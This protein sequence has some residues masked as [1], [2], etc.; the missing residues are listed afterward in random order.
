MNI[1]PRDQA[2][3]A[4]DIT[5]TVN[6][7]RVIHVAIYFRDGKRMNLTIPDPYESAYQAQKLMD[8]SFTFQ[9]KPFKKKDVTAVDVLIKEIGPRETVT[10]ESDWQALERVVKFYIERWPH[11][12]KEF[13]DSISTIR[14]SRNAGGYSE[15]KEIK[16]VAALPYKLERLIKNFF[17]LQQ[18]DK[19]F[20]Y[21]L[22]NKIKLLKVGGEQN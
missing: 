18:Y 22:S 1:S 17:P 15:S 3:T 14:Q 7:V 16:Y 13:S 12:F 8:P 2:S 20:V 5:K 6:T 10:T 21:K 9:M 4:L 19:D 11:D